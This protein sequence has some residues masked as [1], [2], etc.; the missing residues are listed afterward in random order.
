MEIE[1]DQVKPRVFPVLV[2]EQV[3]GDFPRDKLVERFHRGA[4]KTSHDLIY[5]GELYSPG[6]EKEVIKTERSVA[7][8]LFGLAMD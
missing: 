7:A 5:H 2:L 6:P 3:V 1:W 8:L 4:Q